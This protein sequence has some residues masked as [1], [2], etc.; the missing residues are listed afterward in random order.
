MEISQLRYFLELCRQSS[1]SKAA[2]VLNISP[3]G[4]SIAI[5]RLEKELGVELFFR[6]SS[7]LI[8]TEVGEAV[9]K[10]AEAVINHVNKISDLCSIRASGKTD[11]PIV[12]TTGR[13]SKLPTALQKL[14]VTPPEEFSISLGNHYSSTCM[15]LVANGDA[16]FGLVYG[17]C[18]RKK[19]NVTTL[20]IVQQV[21]VVNKKHPFAGKGEISIHE[22]DNMPLVMPGPKTIPGKMIEK[23][24]QENG[25]TLNIALQTLIPRQPV[26]LAS[27]NENVVARA[28]TSDILESD[29]EH[30]SVLK[31]KEY[32][33]TVPFSLISKKDRKLSGHEQLFRHLILD[34]YKN[35]E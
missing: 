29:L 19:L 13:F 12:V 16:T 20:E 31:L 21:F 30:I 18:D 23:M 35:K 15:E 9:R 17:E 22:L 1:M 2:A 33:F 24:F 27:E 6:S 26:I 8:I 5:R 10:E 34:C 3:Q 14:L 28:V 7:G 11:I 4:I 25:M 32:D